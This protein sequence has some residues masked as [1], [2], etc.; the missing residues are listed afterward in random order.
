MP[1]I[2]TSRFQRHYSPIAEALEPGRDRDRAMRCVCD[3]LWSAFGGPGDGRG[4]SWVGFYTLDSSGDQMTL[5]VCRDTPACSP[6]GMHG[7]CGQGCTL[8]QPLVVDDIATLG[9]GYIAC[10]PRDVSE[11]VV[12]LFDTEGLCWGVLD[13]DSHDRGAF[14]D[15][16]VEGLVSVLRASSLTRMDDRLGS[17]VYL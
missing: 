12:P 6:I 13:A 8:G 15:A 7:V 17:P 9:G 3:A 14:S 4:I 10:D 11:V 5:A 16:D 2:P 1:R